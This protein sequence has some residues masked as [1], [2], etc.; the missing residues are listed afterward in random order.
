MS[1]VLTDLECIIIK[2]CDMGKNFS[3]NNASGSRKYSDFYETPYSMTRRFLESLPDLLPT[4]GWLE[5]AA[6]DGA[7]VKIVKEKGYRIDSYDINQGVDFLA[8]DGVGQYK[9]VITNP[10]YSLAYEFIQKAKKV[11]SSKIMFL[12]PLSYLH[13][14][15]RY[16]NVWKD[17]EF[18]LSSIY[19]FVR[20]PLLGDPLREDGK[21]RTGMQVYAWFVWD[22]LCEDEPRIRWIDNNEDIRHSGDQ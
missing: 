19:V 16:C 14:Y 2:E 21:Y 3:M 17:Q 12:L 18:P 1:I 20:Y 22:K 9:V 8:M 15:Q 7:I 6:G 13:G 5:P 4:T 11:S 10:P